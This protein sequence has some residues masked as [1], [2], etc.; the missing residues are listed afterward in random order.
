MTPRFDAQDPTDHPICEQ[1]DQNVHRANYPSTIRPCFRISNLRTESPR[2]VEQ[3]APDAIR[4]VYVSRSIFAT[5]PWRHDCVLSDRRLYKGVVS[6]L[7]VVWDVYRTSRTKA[8][9]KPVPQASVYPIRNC[10]N[11]GI[12]GAAESAVYCGFSTRTHFQNANV[13]GAD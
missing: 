12:T 1:V 10:G 5:S 11:S 7:G 3:N 2:F 9:H 4:K 8:I 13:E 6:T